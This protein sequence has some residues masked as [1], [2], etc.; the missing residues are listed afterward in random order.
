MSG[1]PNVTCPN[2]NTAGSLDLFLG[3]QAAS[4]ALRALATLH[5]SGTRLQSAAMRYVGLFA[6]RKQQMRMDRVAGLL[7]ELQGLLAS[8]RVE[9]EG[10]TYA[11]PLD[12]WIGGMEAMLA[13]RDAGKLDLPIENH[14]YLRS[15]VAGAA[16]KAEAQ[17]EA[18]AERHREDTAAGRTPLPGSRPAAPSSSPAPAPAPAAA[19]PDPRF[20]KPS[21][22]FGLL[23]DA[24]KGHTNPP[25]QIEEDTPH[26]K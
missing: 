16:D 22:G 19:D 7:R 23:R 1:L 24:L 25:N 5:P 26:G 10:A 15:V 14:N 11:A 21:G 4:E 12:Y 20:V 8:G 13:R 18:Q 2:C 6:P 9:W 17:A 3:H